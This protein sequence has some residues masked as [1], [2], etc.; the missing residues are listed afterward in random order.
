[1]L[2][3]D[4]FK[5]LDA[6][7]I[8][9][10][11]EIG[12]KGTPHFQGYIEMK[13]ACKRGYFGKRV[14]LF[15]RAR[16]DSARGSG[17]SNEEY[18][19]KEDTRIE[20]PWRFGTRGTGQGQRTD[21]IAL[22]DAVRDGKRGRELFDDDAICGQAIKYQRGVDAMVSSYSKP[23]MR[24]DIRV[25][26][27][28]GPPGCGKTHCAVEPEQYTFDGNEGGFWLGYKGEANCLFDEFGGH[29][30]KPLQFQRVCDKYPM[31]LPVKGG[32]VPC[33]VSMPGGDN[34]FYIC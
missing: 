23:E 34:F 1:M 27:H 28:F 13:R 4:D 10:Q 5:A 18:C 20:G 25:I 16:L 30:L 3:E 14:D 7:Y 15:Q 9:Y 19:T 6:K 17:D 8:V 29:V 12:K 2:G 24:G 21:L 11:Y 31:W 22:R 32:Q 26:L 33:N